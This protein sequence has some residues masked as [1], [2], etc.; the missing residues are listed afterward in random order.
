MKRL[1]ILFICAM[2]CTSCAAL[3]TEDRSFAVVL[4]MERMADAWRLSARIPTYENGGGYT[5]VTGE[6]GS[7]RSAF[8]ALDAAS[9]MELH[10]G[11]L[12]L[13]VFTAETA[14]S[15]AM[16]EALEA[17]AD[18]HD[19][20]GG[21]YLAV[22]EADMEPLMDAMKP[23]AGS[24]LS[25]SIDVLTETRAAQGTVIALA[26]AEVFLMGERQQPVLMNMT[27]EGDAP[28]LSGVWPVGVDGRASERLTVEETQL[29]SLMLGRMQQGTL[30]LQEGALRVHAVHAEAELLLP[31]LQQASVRLSLRCTDA[32]LAEEAIS[33]AVAT[34]CLGVLNRLSAMNCDAL[35]LGR[36]AVKH[37]D[38][39]TDWHAMA[40]KERYRELD[41]S[42]SVGVQG[43]AK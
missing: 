35:G 24:R 9:P 3:P 12:R 38:D 22:T 20:R 8:A 15:D 26:L 40:W 34:A 6:G 21:A 36:Q 19:L 4:G 42:V 1:L 7:V 14:R 39:M 5:T 13:V 23:A 31:T 17:L 25:K 27:L 2:L 30:S 16:T 28:G 18:R 37:A 32:P 10:L 43:A 11:Q 33:R 29:L 41:W